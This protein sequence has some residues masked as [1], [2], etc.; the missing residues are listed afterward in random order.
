MQNKQVSINIKPLRLGNIKLKVVGDSPYMPEP[1]DMAV[2]DRYD[3]KKSKQS[4]TK[5]S[6]SE[7]DKVKEKYYYTED[8]K[9]G[10]PSRA[11]YN[12]MI[13][14]SSYLFEKRDGGMRNIK[15]GILVKGDILPIKFSHEA[16]LKHWGRTAGQ[17]GAPRK[18]LR[19][20]LYNW[21]VTIEITYNE[22]LLSPEQIFNILN[23]AGF[24][25]G[26]GAFRKEN[27]GNYGMFHADGKF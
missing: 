5:D 2:L 8:G 19:N 22:D 25:I 9:I 14:A 7:A 6:I 23:W 15:E 1:M 21:E 11:F 4:Y 3:Q 10:I 26:V 16:V 13:R 27:T 17:T 12:S 24:H 18:I 20:A